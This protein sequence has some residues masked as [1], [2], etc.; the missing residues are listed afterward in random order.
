[1]VFNK[2]SPI[3][4]LV[5]LLS[6]ECHSSLFSANPSSDPPLSLRAILKPGLPYKAFAYNDFEG[7]CRTN[8]DLLPSST[9]I[10][11]KIRQNNYYSRRKCDHQFGCCVHFYYFLLPSFF[12]YLLSLVNYLLLTQNSFQNF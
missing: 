11:L 1:M 10:L 5:P 9:K 2:T 7:L 12:L 8:K 6:S 4:L 3:V